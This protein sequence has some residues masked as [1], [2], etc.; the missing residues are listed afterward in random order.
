MQNTKDE[1]KAYLIENNIEFD[2]SMTKPE[3]LALISED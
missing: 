2:D 3:L 1:I